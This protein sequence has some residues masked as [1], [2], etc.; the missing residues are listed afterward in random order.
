MYRHALAERDLLRRTRPLAGPRADHAAPDRLAERLEA[1]ER[2]NL[3]YYGFAAGVKGFT[4]SM[5]ETGG[6]NRRPGRP[7]AP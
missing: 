3:A 1:A 7:R 5:I 6:S 2:R 4:L